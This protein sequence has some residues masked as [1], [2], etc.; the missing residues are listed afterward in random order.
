MSQDIQSYYTI[1]SGFNLGILTLLGLYLLINKR[2]VTEANN[3]DFVVRKSTG[4]LIL[5][6]A[7]GYYDI[8]PF[9]HHVV[10][11]MPAKF[12]E[13][14]LLMGLLIGM[15]CVILWLFSLLRLNNT[16]NI[17]RRVFIPL[18]LPAGLAAWY[19]CSANQTALYV[20]YVFWSVYLLLFGINFALEVKKYRKNLLDNFSY[21]RNHRVVWLASSVVALTMIFASFLLSVIWAEQSVT[22]FIFLHQALS[23]A[24]CL[25]LTFVTTR[26]V[27][28]KE[29][30]EVLQES[31]AEENAPLQNTI[32]DEDSRNVWIGR[33]LE[34]LCENEGVYLNPDLNSAML[35]KSVGTN[36]TYLSRYFNSKG[37]NFNHYI[38]SLRIN[39]AKKQIDESVEKPNVTEL[40][41]ECGYRQ[42]NSFRSAFKTFTGMLPSEYINKSFEDR[43]LS[44][45]KDSSR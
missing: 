12:L 23:L 37:V 42:L 36:R 43:I 38:N 45:Q 44:N 34:A 11:R 3:P 2:P 28:E 24:F 6:L 20:S 39:Y 7:L 16:D 32:E 22:P 19:I 25:F 9:W 40:A 13:T 5:S 33:R 8:F 14:N 30:L 29:E 4:I 17:A 15:P 27:A 31:V 1:F 10:D 41:Q 35:S 18:V 26:Q 21:D